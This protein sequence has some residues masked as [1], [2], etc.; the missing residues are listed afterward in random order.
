MKTL[1]SVNQLE[2]KDVGRIHTLVAWLIDDA[3]NFGSP[4][5]TMCLANASAALCS[6]PTS[7]L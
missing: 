7:T 4:M 3:V 2:A 5:H 6:S 1:P